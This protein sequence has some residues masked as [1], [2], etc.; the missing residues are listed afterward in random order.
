MF[1]AH[2]R[3]ART[4]LS[5][6]FV[7]AFFFLRKHAMSLSSSITD[8]QKALTSFKISSFL[9]YNKGSSVSNRISSSDPPA[10]FTLADFSLIDSGS[11][12]EEVTSSIAAGRLREANILKTS[13]KI[14]VTK[15]F[16]PFISCVCSLRRPDSIFIISDFLPW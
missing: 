15:I 12:S 13:K 9:L 4:K 2:S 14:L 16:Y 5:S 11:V 6:K 3:P 8:L 10:C 7:V 1:A